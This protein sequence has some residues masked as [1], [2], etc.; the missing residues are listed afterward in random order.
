MFFR[1]VSERVVREVKGI[2]TEGSSEIATREW[3]S[4]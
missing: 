2:E 1:K 4:I 3:V